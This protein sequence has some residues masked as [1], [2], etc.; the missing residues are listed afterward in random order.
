MALTGELE[1]LHIIDIIQ[2][3]NTT[4]KSGTFSVKGS[5]GESRIIFSNG[6]I[7]GASHLNNKIRIGTVLVKMNAITIEDL[8]RA[9]EIQKN[10]GKNRMPLIS[11]LI[12]LGKLGR[13][14][15]GR[16]LKK[17]IEIVL[18]EMIGW[19][20][21]T[22]TLDTETIAVS[23]ECSYPLSKMEQEINLDAQMLLMDALR[24]YDEQERDRNAGKIV[25]SDEELFTDV[26]QPEGTVKDGGNGPVITADDLGLG[27]IDHMERKMPEFLPD[28][29]TFDPAEIHR[30]KIRETLEGFSAEEQ[31]AFVFF[32]EKATIGRTVHDGPQ[33]Q[34]GEAKGLI[35]FSEDE[36]IK[37]S[38]MTICKA[39]DV[40][41]FAVAGG[42]ELD[43]II[44]Q[45]LKIK[46]LPVLVFDDPETHEGICSREK[47]VRLRRQIR[48]RYPQVSIIQ[49]TS[50]SDYPFALQ[51]FRDGIRAVFPKPSREGQKAT[52]I[53]DTIYLLE[54]LKSYIQGFFQEQQESV[55]A[56]SRLSKIK[57]RILAIRDIN[58]P[59]E[60]PLALLQSVS[61]IFERS[62][63]FIVEGAELTGEKAIGVYADRNAGATS[64]TRL[65]LALSK[66]SV[67]RDAV[68]KGAVF[69]GE[70]D[71][72]VL[73]KDLFEAIGE[74]LSPTIV[75]LPMKR[76]GKTVALTY[77]DFGEKEA[78]RVQTDWLEILANEAGLVLENALYRKK[79]TMVSQRQLHAK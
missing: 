65:K 35:L 2:L 21:G 40:L 75:L 61:E 55:S 23:P 72:E 22:F 7:V 5:K 31:E 27:D 46:V 64:V 15:A 28:D 14:Q 13:E 74:P 42:E 66:S 63:T 62:I 10:A 38:V 16:A 78:M 52:F 54:T 12:G 3:V 77:G 53:P 6:Y 68:E 69:F 67:F 30:Q 43:R 41:V 73:R 50:L 58:E 26:V 70:S 57:D 48:E 4:R 17:L 47:T 51:A 44:E 71:D 8:E 18:V 1:H 25:T 59:S 79:L 33:R 60:V 24:I 19:K 49:M 32:L 29:E 20:E 34:D 56:G 45:C 9:L 36:L 76:R 11:T 39:Q 37:H